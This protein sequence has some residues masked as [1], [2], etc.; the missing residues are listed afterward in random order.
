MSEKNLTFGKSLTV[1]QF[2]SAHNVS[3]IDVKRNKHTNKLFFSYGSMTG[4]VSSNGVPTNRP[5]FSAVCPEGETIDYQHIGEK[6]CSSFW[7]LHEEG[8]GGAEV[9]ATF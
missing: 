4:A 6:G 5:M 9:V 3:T 8:Q 1:E 7:L 2:K